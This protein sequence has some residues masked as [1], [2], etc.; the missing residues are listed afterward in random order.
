MPSLY[1]A[2]SVPAPTV[3]AATIRKQCERWRGHGN[4]E[5]NLPGRSQTLVVKSAGLHRASGTLGNRRKTP[6]Q[7]VER[8][9]AM[10]QRFLPV[11]LR[12]I[13]NVRMARA[14][15]TNILVAFADVR[16]K[17]CRNVTRKHLTNNT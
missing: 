8:A 5:S 6:K 3:R 12:F 14:F 17:E 15:S 7:Q 1:R 10:A 9:Q 4:Q 13:Y 11:C 2:L 16:G